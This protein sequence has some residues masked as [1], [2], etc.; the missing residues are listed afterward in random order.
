MKITCNTV[1]WWRLISRHEHL[2]Q[3]VT[4]V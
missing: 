4:Q 3:N 2:P 1:L